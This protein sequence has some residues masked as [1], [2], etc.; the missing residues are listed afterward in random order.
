MIE[1]SMNERGDKGAE[2]NLFISS[3]EGAENRA[4]QA[5]N[6]RNSIRGLVGLQKIE[7]RKNEALALVGRY[8]EELKNVSGELRGDKDVVLA[9]VGNNGRALKYASEGL[10]DD[11]GVVSVAVSNWGESLEHASERLRAD[12]NVV[13][14]AVGQNGRAL[15]FASIELWGDPELIEL[16]NQTYR[17]RKNSRKE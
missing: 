16:G 10:K 6:L 13:K 14:L 7:Y 15:R 1:T 2:K 5:Q 11:E 12:Q 8:G 4:S 17:Q 3:P 9:A